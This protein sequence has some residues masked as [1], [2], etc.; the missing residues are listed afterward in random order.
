METAQEMIRFMAEH[1]NR[2]KVTEH[3]IED[4][5]EQSKQMLSITISVQKLANN[6]EAMLAEQK[7]Q[8]ERLKK[9]ENEPTE[10][11]T[12]TKKTFFTAI[13]SA[14]GTV[15]AGGILWLFVYAFQNM[16]I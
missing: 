6:M 7:A 16:N 8:G 10:R 3:R 12:S 1:E 11:W 15:L 5:E 9:L 2:M 13:T 14:V 4:L